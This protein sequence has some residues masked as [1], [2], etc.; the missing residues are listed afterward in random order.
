[1]IM[2]TKV[3][4][5]EFRVSFPHVFRARA[6]EEGQEPKFSITM[7][8][9]KDADLSKLEAAAKD[10]I[11]EK[12]GDKPPKKLRSPFRDQAEK[13]E[14]EGYEEGAIFVNATSKSRPG[15]V[16]R[17]VQAIIDEAEFYAGCYARA[18]INAFAYDVKGNRGVA[19]GLQNIQKLR[20]GDPLGG[21]ARPD[22][23]FDP[24]D[25]VDEDGDTDAL[26]D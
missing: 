1:M 5:P 2:A 6:A 20:D 16:D 13:D 25:G 3:M 21:R 4:T 14:Y 24:V 7:L 22:Q 23:D 10:A 15:L 26:W 12:W 8:F 17:D 11:K 9:P 19:F 18:T